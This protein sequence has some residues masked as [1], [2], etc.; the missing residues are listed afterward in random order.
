MD[1]FL[2]VVSWFLATGQEY[3]E[4]GPYDSFFFCFFLYYQDIFSK[5]A[6][7]EMKLI[8]N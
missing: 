1:I 8:I 2:V 3:Y 6:K 5:V 4:L 7:L